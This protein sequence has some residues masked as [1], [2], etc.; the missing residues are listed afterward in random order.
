[1]LALVKPFGL[2]SAMTMLDMAAGLGG[3]ARTVAEAFNTYVAG[4]ERDPLLARLGMEMS[5]T[6]GLGKRASVS[7]ADPESYE[8]KGNHY[9]CVLGREALH[10]VRDKERLLRVLIQGLKPR[11]GFVLTEFLRDRAAGDRAELAQWEA[12]QF[13]PPLLW[14]LDQHV[15]CLKS[16]GLDVRVTEDISQAYCDIIATAWGAFLDKTDLRTLP[17]SHAEAVFGE[18]ERSLAT[19]RALDSGALRMYRIYAIAGRGRTTI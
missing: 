12:Q 18:A 9:D 7:L 2:T 3:P 6:Q 17:R 5:I 4:L 13:P 14:S 10:G 1:V 16:L 19:V 15:D 8:L 11:G